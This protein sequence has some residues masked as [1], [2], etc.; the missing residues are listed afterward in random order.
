LCGRA[1]VTFLVNPEGMVDQLRIV[2][3][4]GHALLDTAA[5]EA[6][7]RAVPLPP[8]AE[9]ARIVIPIVFALQ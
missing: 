9:P 7:S 5:L 3:S 8:S 4:S 1:T 6:V 2:E